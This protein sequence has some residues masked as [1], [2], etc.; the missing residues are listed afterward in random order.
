MIWRIWTPIVRFKA[1]NANRYTVGQLSGGVCGDVLSEMDWQPWLRLLRFHCLGGIPLPAPSALSVPL[2]CSSSL[3]SSFSCIS[4]SHGPSNNLA[5]MARALKWCESRGD[6]LPLP[7]Q[8]HSVQRFVLFGESSCNSLGR[9]AQP[10]VE[11][12]FI[13]SNS[14]KT[15]RYYP[16]QRYAE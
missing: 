2:S 13:I 10:S 6:A 3:G 15:K 8:F 11:G 14:G 12:M 4:T 16:N 1:Q 5:R 7:L 9:R